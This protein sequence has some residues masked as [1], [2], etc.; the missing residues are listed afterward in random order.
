MDFEKGPSTIQT[1]QSKESP[2]EKRVEVKTK[3]FEMEDVEEI[4]SKL[5]IISSKLGDNLYKDR[6][7][8]LGENKE[9]LEKRLDELEDKDAE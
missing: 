8:E 5:E 2:E 1:E 6:A 4:K 3:I 7:K 9:W